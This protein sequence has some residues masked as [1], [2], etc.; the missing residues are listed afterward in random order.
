MAVAAARGAEL[1]LAAA[2]SLDEAASELGALYEARTGVRVRTV[3]GGSDTLAR[4]IG[5][6]ASIDVFVSA[7]RRTMEELV[8][9]GR[10][11]A[12]TPLLGNRLVVVVARD[13]DAGIGRTEDLLELPRI[14]IGD[15]GGVPAG[16]Y[17]REWLVRCGLWERLEARC[18]GT[19][20]VRAALAAVEAGN[21]EAAIVY[22]TDAA[23]SDRVRIAYEA[24]VGESPRVV[25]PVAVCTGA[26]D[27]AR[28]GDFVRFL[29]GEAAAAVFRKRGFERAEA[30]PD[31]PVDGRPDPGGG[32]LPGDL[33]L[34]LFT[35]GAAALAVLVSLPFALALAWALARRRWWGKTLVESLVLLPLVVPP[36]VTG[37]ALLI[38]FGRHG[39]LG[40]P[41]EEYLGIQVVFTW[42]AVVLAMAVVSFPLQ[43]GSIRTALEEIPAPLESAARTLG[44]R[45][46]RVFFRVSLPLARRG[47][48]SGLLLG[49]S[50]ALGEFGATVMVA[51]FIPG[52]TE[53]LPLAIYR[54]VQTGD[55]RRAWILAG[56]SVAISV[57]CVAVVQ[58]YRQGAI[59]GL[60]FGRR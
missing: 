8:A 46:W 38:L 5:H 47:I 36:V 20:H 13:S 51:G 32:L 31:A 14:A 25:Y 30:A 6:G 37:L 18:V 57:V 17:A 59:A 1:R 26:S 23:V 54:G 48:G 29:R 21:V 27:V 44:T 11:H 10:V 55:D 12:A 4:Q 56:V 45:P 33:R 60:R 42:K 15:P 3:L 2:A 58:R 28:A 9:S 52:L 7:D 49:F 41:L 39:P 22:R 19:E 53:T 24:P 34:M 43:V 50:R 35:V 40:A 16:V